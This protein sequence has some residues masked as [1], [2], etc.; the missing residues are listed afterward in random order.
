MSQEKIKDQKRNGQSIF[1]KAQFL[2]FEKKM[3]WHE[4]PEKEEK[5]Y[6]TDLEPPACRPV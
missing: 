2:S 5:T 1:T 4:N 3:K 6:S